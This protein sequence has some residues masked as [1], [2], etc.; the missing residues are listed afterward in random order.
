MLMRREAD[1]D[2]HVYQLDFAQPAPAH[3]PTGHLRCSPGDVVFVPKSR[4]RTATEFAREFLEVL[5]RGATTALVYNELHG[6]TAAR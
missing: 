3:R 1:G 6:R 5:G 4:F 2:D